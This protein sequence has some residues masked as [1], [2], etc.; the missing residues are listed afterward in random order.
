MPSP[1]TYDLYKG[2]PQTFE[3]FAMTCARAFVATIMMRDEPLAAPIREFEPSTFASDE[4]RRVHERIQKLQAMSPDEIRAAEA[5][6]WANLTEQNERWRGEQAARRARYEAMRVEVEAWT[7]PTAEHVEL[8]AFMADQLR[9][10]IESESFEYDLGERLEP[11]AW[12]AAQ[13]AKANRAVEYFQKEEAAE[14]ARA[15]SRNAWVR[16]LRES[17]AVP[18]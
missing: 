12:W 13:V 17:L 8:K 1:Y 3:Q 18:T 10:A 2:K 4:L 6:E 16:A 9:Q 14:I 5:T 15:D 11:L 7:P